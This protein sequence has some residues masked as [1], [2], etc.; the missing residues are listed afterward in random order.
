MSDSSTL[1]TH[2]RDHMAPSS[3]GQQGVAC[4]P[5]R[6]SSTPGT[7]WTPK[8][9]LFRAPYYDFLIGVLEKVGSLGSRKY[10]KPN[11]ALGF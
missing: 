10:L 8:N 9:L 3:S 2:V 1:T 5:F 6:G 7:T 11:R 4:F